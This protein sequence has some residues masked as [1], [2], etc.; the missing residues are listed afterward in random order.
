MN[1][2][3]LSQ[4]PKDAAQMHCDK[5][6]VKMVTELSQQLA[7]AV[8][9]HGAKDN[10]MPLTKSGTPAKGG[11]KH[12]PCTIWCG[13]TRANFIWA[14]EHAIYLA[15]EYTYRY[16]KIHFCESGIWMMRR[17]HELIPDGE[18]TKFALAMPEKFHSPSAVE[19]YRN[20]YY[21]DKRLNIKC[22]WKK[23]RPAPEWWD[24][25]SKQDL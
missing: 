25:M 2:F 15:E 3:V 11:Y 7:S 19:A 12:H 16:N 17:M 8:L 1:I 9:R 20:Y 4:N 6:V 5:H 18:I 13:D 21:W 10:E 14:A 22:E 24:D 23:K